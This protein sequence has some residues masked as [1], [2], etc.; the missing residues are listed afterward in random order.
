MG[1]LR[2]IILQGRITEL[3][4]ENGKLRDL[5]EDAGEIMTLRDRAVEEQHDRAEKLEKIVIE[6]GGVGALPIEK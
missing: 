1:H 2:N 4:I 6:L 5:V 3:E